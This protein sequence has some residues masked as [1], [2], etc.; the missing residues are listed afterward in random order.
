MNNE[1]NK[2]LAL[3]VWPRKYTSVGGAG[4]VKTPPPSPWIKI[5]SASFTKIFKKLFFKCS[6]SSCNSGL[7]SQFSL[8]TNRPFCWIGVN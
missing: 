6:G 5:I 4:G 3:F 2:V 7:Y 8:H 1:P